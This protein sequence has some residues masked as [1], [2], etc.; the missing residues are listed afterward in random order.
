MGGF[1]GSEK[2]DVIRN[3]TDSLWLG[4]EAFDESSEVGVEFGTP[5]GRDHRFPIFRREDDVVMKGSVGRRHD[6]RWLAPLPGCGFRGDEGPVV[7]R[8]SRS[9]TGYRMGCLRHRE[10]GNIPEG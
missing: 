9:T 7:S 5:G 3:T 8:L 4:V 10:R 1:Q 6:A 2:M